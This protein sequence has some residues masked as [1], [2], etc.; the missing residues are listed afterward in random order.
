MY[1]EVFRFSAS[2]GIPS[3]VTVTHSPSR[4]CA[5]E[6]RSTGLATEAGMV[7]ADSST[8]HSIAT[9]IAEIKKRLAMPAPS[10]SVYC[11]V[12][13]V[14]VAACDAFDYSGNFSGHY[15]PKTCLDLVSLVS[16][17][18]TQFNATK[19]THRCIIA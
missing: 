19:A 10:N 5:G 2:S 16:V 13:L 18:A 3:H 17:G 7:E 14:L 4:I 6:N 11:S 12:L 15:P 8:I 1:S 9:R